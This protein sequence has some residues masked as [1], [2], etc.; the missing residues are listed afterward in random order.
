M[1]DLVLFYIPFLFPLFYFILSFF[2]F[3]LDISEENKM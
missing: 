1:M 3:I 2:F